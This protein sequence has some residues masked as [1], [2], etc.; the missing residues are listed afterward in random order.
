[1][2]RRKKTREIVIHRFHSAAEPQPK[3]GFAG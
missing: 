1:V 3:G 2:R